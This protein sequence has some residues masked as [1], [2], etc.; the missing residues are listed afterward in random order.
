MFGMMGVF[1][2]FERNIIQA[3]VKAGMDRAKA[4]QVTGKARRD[5]TGRLLK[6]IGRPKTPSKPPYAPPWPPA[7]VLGRQPGRSSLALERCNGLNG[8]MRRKRLA[9]TI[10]SIYP[11]VGNGPCN[12]VRCGGA[13]FL[14][15][16]RPGDR[17][18]G[19]PRCWGRRPLWQALAEL[20]HPPPKYRGFTRTH[21]R[22]RILKTRR[23]TRG[24][25]SWSMR[26]NSS[27]TREIR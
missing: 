6:A 25:C 16:E 22:R 3:R 27:P 4:E 18:H 15:W 13:R 21:W 7:W 12:T 17:W 2:D 11:A 9:S 24:G 26:S 20:P 8:R 10:A 14:R 5:S 19:H 23:A 1:A